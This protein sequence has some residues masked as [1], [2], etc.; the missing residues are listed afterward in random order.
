MTKTSRVVLKDREVGD[1]LSIDVKDQLGKNFV[2]QIDKDGVKILSCQ[3]CDQL[4]KSALK[5]TKSVCDKQVRYKNINGTLRSV[6]NRLFSTS[7][8]AILSTMPLRNNNSNNNATTAE[9]DE[10]VDDDANH[11]PPADDIDDDANDEKEDEDEDEDER[12]SREQ[13]ENADARHAMQDQIANDAAAA[14]DEYE[15]EE[16]EEEE[17]NESEAPPAK[18]T[19]WIN[20]ESI[21]WTDFERN[22]ANKRSG[23]ITDRTEVETEEDLKN[24]LGRQT[25][26][27]VEVLFTNPNDDSQRYRG[28][29][30]EI[31]KR[32]IL[33]SK[34]KPRITYFAFKMSWEKKDGVEVCPEFMR[35][36]EVRGN[37]PPNRVSPTIIQQKYDESATQSGTDD[38]LQ[39]ERKLAQLKYSNGLSENVMGTFMEITL[40][41]VMDVSV[42]VA[43]PEG[44]TDDVKNTARER[45]KQVFNERYS[46]FTNPALVTKMFQDQTATKYIEKTTKKIRGMESKYSVLQHNETLLALRKLCAHT[47]FHGPYQHINSEKKREFSSFFSGDL[48][49][50]LQARETDDTHSI[51]VYVAVDGAAFKNGKDQGGSYKAVNVQIAY[52][53]NVFFTLGFIYDVDDRLFKLK[54]EENYRRQNTGKKITAEEIAKACRVAKVLLYSLAMIDLLDPILRVMETTDPYLLP[55]VQDKYGDYRRV[56]FVI[57]GFLMDIPEVNLC[58]GK[59]QNHSNMRT[60][61]TR[62]QNFSGKGHFGFQDEDIL[63]RTYDHMRYLQRNSQHE[64]LINGCNMISSDQELFN[65]ETSLMARLRASCVNPYTLFVADALHVK[66]GIVQLLMMELLQDFVKHKTQL[67]PN[68][69]RGVHCWLVFARTLDELMK[70]EAYFPNRRIPKKGILGAV[71]SY[72]SYEWSALM[73]SIGPLLAAVDW[74]RVFSQRAEAVASTNNIISREEV[75][76]LFAETPE[77]RER[78]QTLK[79]QQKQE[80]EQAK[81]KQKP[82]KPYMTQK[83]MRLENPLMM[84]NEELAAHESEKIAE[85]VKEA[86][87]AKKAA[88][89]AEK[90][91][92]LG[93]WRQVASALVLFGRWL[94]EL[95]RSVHT[96]E[97]L[98][99]LDELS[100]SVLR[101][102]I[103]AFGMD[104]FRRQAKIAMVMHFVTDVLKHGASTNFSTE[105]SEHHNLTLRQIAPSTRGDS[106]TARTQMME[107]KIGALISHMLSESKERT[108]R[109]TNV[110]PKFANIM[111]KTADHVGF[112]SGN[113]GASKWQSIGSLCEHGFANNLWA[114]NALLYSSRKIILN[115]AHELILST[116]DEDERNQNEILSA[117]GITTTTTTQIDSK[118]II[119]RSS[120]SAYVR[121][122]NQKDG[123]ATKIHAR[124]TYI[125]SSDVYSFVEY[126][127]ESDPPNVLRCGQMRSIFTTVVR[128][129]ND[130]G[131]SDGSISSAR[132]YVFIKCLEKVRN[133]NNILVGL[134]ASGPET[135]EIFKW[136]SRHQRTNND[137]IPAN[138]IVRL[139]RATSF[140][141]KEIYTGGYTGGDDD[142]DHD[143]HDD[144]DDGD[145]NEEEVFLVNYLV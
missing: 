96:Y 68:N 59:L 132:T 67:K 46:R 5:H 83:R 24:Y 28:K 81:R 109:N 91:A 66:A 34:S 4:C 60:V 113:S 37:S 36:E 7:R 82:R 14:A 57:V 124:E 23:K 74:V 90:D 16:E 72:T 94:T 39:L 64:K 70:R 21:N 108:T 54:F 92:K 137:L 62:V 110:G 118:L 55:V 123:E 56:R 29:S 135:Y 42:L 93:S 138:S 32:Y 40:S 129:D 120:K 145:D 51:P 52:H 78:I 17:R 20:L 100:S 101:H 88:K 133:T 31:V 9:K 111:N 80:Q 134:G 73:K 48:L 87:R 131:D 33:G 75:N 136:K 43:C 65:K 105:S 86:K 35:L 77:E 26:G 85:T 58:A 112:Q 25:G 139:L 115:F 13:Q 71:S 117:Q 1:V 102:L 41:A 122:P 128:K 45:A 127:D 44:C 11:D 95:E 84:T 107:N 6:D 15:E 119:V 27:S 103:D 121:L 63:P 126:R 142:D 3:K 19:D 140:K 114:E 10:T 30:S 22:I 104:A 53:P 89:A 98:E 8:N 79:Q 47:S 61:A 12:Q 38:P 49:Y 130:N 97:S 2:V 106:I 116:R 76:L 144:H 50:A 125:K 143:D 69:A 141:A 99:K 18:K